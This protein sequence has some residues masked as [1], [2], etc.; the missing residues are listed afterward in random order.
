MRLRA[1][2]IIVII[3]VVSWIFQRVGQA[4][5][6]SQLTVLQQSQL[7]SIMRYLA[8]N[9]TLLV[10]DTS[11]GTDKIIFSW[12]ASV[13]GSWPGPSE[14]HLRNGSIWAALTGTASWTAPV[15]PEGQTVPCG[16]S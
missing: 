5:R 2:I 12:T 11:V 13:F 4:R 15:G 9:S 16:A 14:R 6:E 1:A 10:G 7:T 3:S 8:K